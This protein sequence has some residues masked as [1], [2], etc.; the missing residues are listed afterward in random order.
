M[1][2][3]VNY[4]DFD[5]PPI[6]GG[7]LLCYLCFTCTW[8]SI[9]EETNLHLINVKL[10]RYSKTKFNRLADFRRAIADVELAAIVMRR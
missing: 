1:Q 5:A 6:I 3:R 2:S 4:L 9:V 7:A 8:F 10:L